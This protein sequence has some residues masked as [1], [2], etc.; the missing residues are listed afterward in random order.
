MVVSVTY[1]KYLVGFGLCLISSAQM[2]TSEKTPTKLA[3]S[4]KRP[5]FGLN[6]HENRINFSCP[7]V[8]NP[9]Q[10]RGTLMEQ[11]VKARMDVHTVPSYQK[12]SQGLSI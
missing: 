4:A 9:N 6:E 2:S 12:M 7:E 1:V 8:V 10:G 5:W 3:V 11:H